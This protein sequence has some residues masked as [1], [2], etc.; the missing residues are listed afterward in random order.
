MSTVGEIT[1][2][3]IIQVVQGLLVVLYADDVALSTLNKKGDKTL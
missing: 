1:N 2:D 3:L